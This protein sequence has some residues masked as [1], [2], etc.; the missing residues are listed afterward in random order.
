MVAGHLSKLF[1]IAEIRRGYWVMIAVPGYLQLL[2]LW[3][4]LASHVRRVERIGAY[5]AWRPR[6]PEPPRGEQRP[7]SQATGCA[8]GAGTGS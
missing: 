5:A 4:G 3:I 7:A 1:D 6:L 2:V 8:T